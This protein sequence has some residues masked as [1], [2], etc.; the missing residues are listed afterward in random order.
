MN[1]ESP[2][3]NTPIAICGGRYGTAPCAK[4]LPHWETTTDSEGRF[5][6]E[7]VPR[8]KFELKGQSGERGHKVWRDLTGKCCDDE[9]T[10]VTLGFAQG[11]IY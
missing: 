2:I 5:T 10:E 3:P 6:F 9:A 1:G 8:W 7:K 4:K 11:A